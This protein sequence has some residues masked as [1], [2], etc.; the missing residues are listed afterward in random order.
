MAYYD[1]D[2]CCV[3]NSNAITLDSNRYGGN[4]FDDTDGEWI[5]CGDNQPISKDKVYCCPKCGSGR[6]FKSALTKFCPNCG[7]KLNT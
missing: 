3:Y 2:M 1:E 5:E 7:V 4:A 6:Y